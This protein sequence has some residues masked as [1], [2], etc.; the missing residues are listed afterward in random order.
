MFHS[1]SFWC[2]PHLV[3][4]PSPSLLKTGQS[5][6]YCWLLPVRKHSN[7]RRDRLA[8]GPGMGWKWSVF[9]YIPLMLDTLPSLYSD[10]LFETVMLMYFQKYLSQISVEPSLQISAALPGNKSPNSLIVG[11]R[12]QGQGCI[13]ISLFRLMFRW[14]ILRSAQNQ[15]HGKVP[16]LVP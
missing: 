5:S 16:Q 12:F 2:I 1:I 15:S 14:K 10:W 4:E 11:F 7:Y 13:C 3:R 8:D 9:V 6:K